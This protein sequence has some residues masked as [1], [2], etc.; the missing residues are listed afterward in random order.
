MPVLSVAITVADPKVSR[1]YNFFTK[2]FLLLNLVATN[3]KTLI[4]VEGNPIIFFK[5]HIKFIK[6]LKEH[7]RLL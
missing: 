1:V 2:I 3:D 7:L 5:H 6:Y 4:T